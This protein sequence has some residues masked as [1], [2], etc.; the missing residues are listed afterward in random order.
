M[1]LA[2]LC[3]TLL[4]I[5]HLGEEVVVTEEYYLNHLSPEAKEE[6][7]KGMREALAVERANFKENNPSQ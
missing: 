5:G 4:K 7:N 1:L 2:C 3:S 6:W